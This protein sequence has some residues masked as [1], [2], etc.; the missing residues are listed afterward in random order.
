MVIRLRAHPP[1]RVGK[2]LVRVNG[3]KAK[4]ALSDKVFGKTVQVLETDK[5]RYGR[6]VAIVLTGDDCVNVQLVQ[7]GLAWHYRQFSDSNILAAVEAQA[8]AKQAGL[9][10]DAEPR[11]PWEFR[12]KPAAKSSPLQ[13]RNSRLAAR[14]RHRQRAPLH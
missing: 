2:S 3:N 14:T 6:I 10:A 11:P 8:R 9:W 5:D 7:E 4:Q 13:A 12:R 1:Q